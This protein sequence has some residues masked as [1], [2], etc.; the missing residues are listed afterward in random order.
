MIIFFTNSKSTKQEKQEV[1]NQMVSAIKHYGHQVVSLET[2]SYEDLLDMKKAQKNE[3]KMSIHNQYIR[4]AIELADA[5]VIE[6]SRYSFKLGQEVQIALD[7]KVPVLLLSDG[8]DYSEKVQDPYFY[9]AVYKEEKDIKNAIRNF[10]ETVKSR[11]LNKRIN[12]FL[13]NK[14]INYLDW[15]V[16]THDGSNRSELIRDAL[17][18][19]IDADTD[20]KKR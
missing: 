13:H 8:I 15:Y 7:K 20:Y 18:S 19:M 1:F 5:A 9:S 14:H 4:K 2:Q 16:K 12:V 11:H 3:K 17:E 6:A 10:M